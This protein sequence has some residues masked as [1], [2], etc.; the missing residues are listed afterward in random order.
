MFGQVQKKLKNSII[1]LRFIRKKVKS[2][3]NWITHK[4]G[5]IEEVKV[6]SRGN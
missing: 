6:K 3:N 4:E 1:I 5:K 2:S